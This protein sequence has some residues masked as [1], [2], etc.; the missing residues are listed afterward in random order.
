MASLQPLLVC[1]EV[2]EHRH[3]SA[4]QLEC[5]LIHQFTDVL[6]IHNR[7][8]TCNKCF[9]VQTLFSVILFGQ[10]CYLDWVEFCFLVI[11][12]TGSLTVCLTQEP[13]IS[14]AHTSCR[15]NFRFV[16]NKWSYYPQGNG[17]TIFQGRKPMALLFTFL[18]IKSPGIREQPQLETICS[19]GSGTFN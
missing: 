14:Y 8:S 5:F 15:L 16:T 19:P 11:G 13:A 4:E 10:S 7:F 12:Q 1:F 6:I 2:K 18:F 3:A 9:R 17:Y